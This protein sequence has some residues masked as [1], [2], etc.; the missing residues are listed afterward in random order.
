MS[1]QSSNNRILTFKGLIG[2]IGTV[3]HFPKTRRYPLEKYHTSQKSEI[4]MSKNGSC[5]GNPVTIAT[6]KFM[7][8]GVFSISNCLC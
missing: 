7:T 6:Q 2:V 1:I 5:D 3:Y 4:L 8:Y